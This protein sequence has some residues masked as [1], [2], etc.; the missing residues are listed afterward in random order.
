MNCRW[1]SSLTH[2]W[3][4]KEPDCPNKCFN[5]GLIS[6]NT[7]EFYFETTWLSIFHCLVNR[8]QGTDSGRS[9]LARRHPTH[10]SLQPQ[11][12]VVC[13]LYQW[14]TSCVARLHQGLHSDRRSREAQQ[15]SVK[16]INLKTAIKVGPQFWP[17][18][19]NFNNWN[20]CYR[21]VKCWSQII[22]SLFRKNNCTSNKFWKWFGFESTYSFCTKCR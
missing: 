1:S 10:P 5:C 18:E 6:L 7:G 15:A 22:Q 16:K 13:Q 4:R 20:V 3:P 17:V 11:R 9:Q 21:I 14:W 2:S 8:Q 12:A 19:I